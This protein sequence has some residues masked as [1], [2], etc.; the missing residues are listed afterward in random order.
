MKTLVISAVNFTEGGP[1]TVLRDCVQA[2]AALPGWRVVVMA[3]DGALID[4]PGVQVMAYPRTKTS[5]LRRVA[6]EWWG[7]ERVSRALR[8]DLWLSLHDVTPR[9]QARRQAVYCHNP[10]PFSRPSLR[11]IW[12]EPK[13]LAFSLLY[14]RLYSAF[15][16]RNRFVVVQQAWLRQEFER[17]Y[18]VSS[19]IVAHPAG[20][21]TSAV[22]A[23]PARRDGPPVFFYPAIARCFKNFEVVGRALEI[24]E[25][26]TAWQGSVHWTLDGSENRY[27][28][29]LKRRF[30]HL[31]SLHWS[32]RLNRAQMQQHYAQ[33]HCLLFPSR[34]ETWGLP[35]TEAKQ[36]GLPLLV[37]DLPYAR[38]TVGTWDR[39]AFFA[40][41]D[42]PALARLMAAVARGHKPFEPVRQ[43]P[44]DA[45]YAADWHA[46]M[47]QL[48]HEL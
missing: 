32:G 34:V 2:A 33:A 22:P 36:A 5:W 4:T 12:F 44:P 11:D 15:I 42:A 45:P 16:R 7:F 46:L 40:P 14:G 17:R 3:H 41:H 6:L 20:E 19:V 25:A 21:A 27:A 47:R 28:R 13:F 35:I 48:T 43:A 29:W 26:D 37:A 24:L 39:V 8:A 30:G 1:L 23:T 18:G 10:A 38:E 9:V 31:R